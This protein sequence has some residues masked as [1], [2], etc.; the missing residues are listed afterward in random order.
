MTPE[1]EEGDAVVESTAINNSREDAA[2][3][4]SAAQEKLHNKWNLWF[5]NP[6]A[7][8]PNS[9][10]KENLQ[11]CG[12]FDTPAKFWQI[13]NNVKPSSQLSTQCNYHI[14]KEGI[15][16]MWED[17]QNEQGGK[18]VFTIPKGKNSNGTVISRVDEFWLFT[19]L[20][21]IGETID[22]TGDMVCGA[23]VSIR[24]SQDRIALWIKTNEPEIVSKIGARWKIALNVPNKLK[25]QVH[26]DGM[27]VY[28]R[29]CLYFT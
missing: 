19:C 8:A 4:I 16:P 23:V 28:A 27:Y 24:K 3:A 11:L 1:P 7:A 2:A 21:V 26:R 29:S 15:Q 25:Y 10:W 22:F 12:T 20:A 5:D 14:F 13:F 17:P 6:K 18:W 9:D